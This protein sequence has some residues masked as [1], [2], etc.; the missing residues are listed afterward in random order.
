MTT[1]DGKEQQEAFSKADN[2]SEV[3]K[4]DHL[5]AGHVHKRQMH[6]CIKFVFLFSH[7]NTRTSYS[8]A[9]TAHFAGLS[10]ADSV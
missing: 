1:G 4:Q 2:R 6:R 8:Y 5:P 10:S 9:A 3:T 7:L